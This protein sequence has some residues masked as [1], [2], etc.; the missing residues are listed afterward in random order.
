MARPAAARECPDLRPEI[1][2]HDERAGATS[3]NISTD[4]TIGQ[5]AVAC[6]LGW[7]DFRYGHVD[8]RKDHPKVAAFAQKRAICS[9]ISAPLVCRNSVSP[10]A[11]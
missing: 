1:A 10:L 9:S 5:I 4:L 2:H 3:L 6:A 7:F 8:W 11:S